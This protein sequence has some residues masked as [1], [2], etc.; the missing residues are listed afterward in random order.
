MEFVD[1]FLG[2]NAKDPTLIMITTA[3]MDLTYPC[4]TVEYQYCSKVLDQDI[5]VEDEAYLIDILEVNIELLGNLSNLDNRR[6]WHMANPIR[7]SY[8]DGKEKI[9]QSYNAA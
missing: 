1:L 8:A 9:A 4:Y 2:A 3:G 7:M 6:Y 5:D